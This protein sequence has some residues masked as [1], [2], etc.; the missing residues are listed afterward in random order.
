MSVYLI[1]T[2]IISY[3]EDFNSPF[4]NTL[5]DKMASLED[6]D[7][8]CISILSLYE[9]EYSMA[10]ADK[11]LREGLLKTKRTIKEIFQLLPLSIDGAEIFGNLKS[12]YQKS[13]G[14]SKKA[15]NRHNVDLMLASAA[16]AENAIMVSND[17]IFQDLTKITPELKYE[18]WVK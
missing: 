8:L 15:I 2:N 3:L 13:T 12:T 6:S 9:F 16:I 4:Y 7:T 1:D 18:N 17:N 14:I 11:T 10:H 5:M